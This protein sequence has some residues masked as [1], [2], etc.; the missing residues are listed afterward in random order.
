MAITRPLALL[1]AVSLVAGCASFSQDGGFGPVQQA[2]EL[3]LDKQLLWA[4]DEAGRGQ[5]DARV[6]ELLADPLSLDAAV[7]LALLNNRGL[8]ASLD[9]LGIGEAERVQAGRLPNPGFSYGRL[10]KGSE[11]EYE[12]GL[13]LN[14][15]RLI[16]LPLTSRLEG[17]RFE[18]L[19]RQTSLAVFELASETRKAWYEAVAAEESAVYA[20]QVLDAAEVGGELARRMAAVGNFSKLQQ[21]EQQAFYAE[22]GI[23]LLQA[24][25]ARVRS[26]ERLTRLLGLW[27]EQLDY[28]LPERLPA[29]PKSADQLPDVERLAMSQRQDIQAVRLDAERLAQNLG[30]TRTTRFINVLELGVVN[31]RSNE[32]PTQR[33]YEI[34]VELPLF[35]W[36]GARVARAEAQY[37]QALNRAAE[38]AINARSQ[39]REAYHAYRNAFELAQHYRAEVLPL[40]QRIAEENLLRYNGMFISTFDLLADARRQVQA[41]DGYLQ[42]Q[43]DFWLARADLDMALLGAPNPSLAAAPAAT[44]EPAAAGH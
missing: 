10:E 40:R 44:A 32:E 42:A 7:Q 4:R 24:E 34:S 21:V 35:D 36:S 27:G 3:Q 30:L 15:A 8:Q 29:L 33:G 17:Q 25:Q 18:Q 41:V 13:H 16:A 11:V 20:R 37:R 5:I 43:R 31:N 26:R 6:T 14:L 1:C 9:E 12:R 39:V 23:G 19:Q 22:A 28:R 38:T 2:S